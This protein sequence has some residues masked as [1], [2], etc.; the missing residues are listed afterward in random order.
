MCSK[1]SITLHTDAVLTLANDF[2]NCAFNFFLKLIDC[3]SIKVSIYKVIQSNNVFPILHNLI[4]GTL[5]LIRIVCEESLMIRK[6]QLVASRL[7]VLTTEQQGQ[8]SCD[9]LIFDALKALA[10]TMTQSN[11]MTE[12]ALFKCCFLIPTD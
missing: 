8:L 4:V 12:S 6:I 2:L 1:S 3:D 11:T 10:A 9:S 5:T 7:L